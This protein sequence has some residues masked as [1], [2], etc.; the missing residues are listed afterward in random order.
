MQSKKKIAV[1]NDVKQ[2]LRKYGR[3][4]ESY[5]DVIVKLLSHADSCN[6][7]VEDWF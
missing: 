4:G 1:S 5:N 7:F 6:G 2:G 3:F